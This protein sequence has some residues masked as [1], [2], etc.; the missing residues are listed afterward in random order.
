MR[1]AIYVSRMP[2]VCLSYVSLYASLY[3]SICLST[4]LYVSLCAARLSAFRRLLSG[5]LAALGWA[6]CRPT[7]RTVSQ[8][9]VLKRWF[10]NVGSQTLDLKS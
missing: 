2:L 10:S 1:L 8:Q 4:S 6:G 9:L 5:W 3:V 7:V